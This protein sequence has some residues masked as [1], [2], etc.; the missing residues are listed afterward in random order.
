MAAVVLATA[1]VSTPARAQAPR[2][3][4]LLDVPYLPQSEALCGGA[5]IAMVM[6]YWG[7]TGVYAET[8]SDLVDGEA[9]G[10]R[11]R[12][13]VQALVGRGYETAAFEG[14]L[15]HIHRSLLGRRP[16]IA[17]IE[18]RPGRFHYVVIVGLRDEG[19]VVHDPA[20]APFRVIDAADFLRAWTPAKNWM[21]VADPRATTW[22]PARAADA[23]AGV[24]D[25]PGSKSLC[26]GMVDE[27]VPPT[28]SPTSTSASTTTTTRPSWSTAAS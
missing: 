13:L 24:P 8:F 20:R 27:G 14:S 9:Q 21:L 12:D 10:I 4:P 7:A 11:G 17:L 15:E 3:L 22:L 19:I 25:A 6:R 1:A 23:P 26:A 2:S 16:A 18:D 5:A 28:T